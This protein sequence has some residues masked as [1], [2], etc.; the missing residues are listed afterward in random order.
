MRHPIEGALPEGMK[1]PMKLKDPLTS[2]I[3]ILGRMDV[4]ERPVPQARRP[5]P[6]KGTR[7]SGLRVSTL[8]RS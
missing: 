1:P 6:Q 8:R 4:A 3:K 7:V 2:R 5:K